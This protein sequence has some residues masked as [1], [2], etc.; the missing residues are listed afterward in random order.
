MLESKIHHCRL[1]HSGKLSHLLETSKRHNK[2]VADDL[3]LRQRF[4]KTVKRLFIWGAYAG[5]I[6]VNGARE[7]GELPVENDESA[8][9]SAIVGGQSAEA[10]S[11]PTIESLI[12]LSL[13]DSLCFYP[14]T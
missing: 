10:C 1:V 13:L 4:S 14:L 2:F 11:I 8:V 7:T 3:I 5:I 6:V 12:L 9:V